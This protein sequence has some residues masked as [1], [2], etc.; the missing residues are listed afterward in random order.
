MHCDAEIRFMDDA[1]WRHENVHE[2]KGSIQIFQ[3]PRF[4]CSRIK[5][6]KNRV[7][8]VVWRWGDYHDFDKEDRKPL[9]FGYTATI[10][11]AEV[12]MSEIVSP[13]PESLIDRY[14]GY[15]RAYHR[16]LA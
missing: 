3:Y 9:A 15:A 12:L 5:L 7:F 4:A 2:N 13:C 16:E 14:G 1:K 10:A 11:E 6:G 8:Y